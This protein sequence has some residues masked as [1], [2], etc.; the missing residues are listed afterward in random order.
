MRRAVW[1]RAWRSDSAS[2]L[3][4][5][6]AFQ[7]ITCS[8]WPPG[9]AVAFPEKKSPRQGLFFFFFFKGGG[10][11]EST[12][13]KHRSRED[14][15]L[16]GGELKHDAFREAAWQPTWD[17]MT[18]ALRSLVQGNYG[19]QNYNLKRRCCHRNHSNKDN[20]WW[21]VE[22][23]GEAILQSWELRRGFLRSFWNEVR[24][25]A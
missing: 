16:G 5:W 21:L 19:M 18:P 22:V 24:K 17:V 12:L 1:F 10:E 2:K 23:S 20:A 7:V 8:V 6:F 4:L 11:G 13:W 9:S 14:S 3:K 25:R 15:G